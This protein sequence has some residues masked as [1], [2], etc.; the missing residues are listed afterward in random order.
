M[1]ARR[2]AS[3]LLALVLLAGC[4]PKRGGAPS[5]LLIGVDGAD[6]G[7][8]DRL[9]GEG[10]LPTFARLKREGASGRLRSIEPLLSPIVWT[11]I[12]TGRKPQDHGI[13]D[14][15]EIGADGQPTPITS[16]RRKVP[17]LWNIA[18]EF[19]K[20]SGFVGWYASYPAEKVAGFEVSDRLA[21]HQVS[22][23]RATEG[24]T[25]P[26]KLSARL[27]AEFG[28]PRPDL[29]ATKA[30]FLD[31]PA[32]A[33][34][35]DG[36]RRI[37]ELS[38]IHA[39]SEFYRRIVPGLA[40]REPTDLVAVYFEMVDACGHLFMEDAPPKRDDVADADFAAFHDTVDR[41]YQYQDRVLADLLLLEGPST[42][43]IVVSDHGFKSGALRPRTSGRADTGLAPLWHQLHGVVFV[44]GRGARAG[45]DI[46][47]ATVLD[48]A[49]TV[50]DLLG[51]PRSDEFPG[52]SLSRAFLPGA[53]PATSKRVAAYPRLP[54]RRL[55]PRAASDPESVRKLAALGYLGGGNGRV[56]AHDP[57]GR[58]VAS[59]LN[60]GSARAADGDNRGALVDFGKA[61]EIDPRNVNALIYAA[62]LYVMDGN[63]ERARELQD[64]A[65]AIDPENTA[66]RLQRASWAIDTGHL[67]MAE[68]ELAAVERK[69]DNLSLFH[70][71]KA[72]LAEGLGRDPDAMA[73]LASAEKLTDSDAF[74][75]EILVERAGLLARGG[76]GAAA[77]AE[78]VRAASVMPPARLAE[79]RGDLAMRRRDPAAASRF[80][81]EASVPAAR[82]SLERKFG[83]ALA[84]SGD[85]PAAEQAFR[86]A[87]KRAVTPE[88]REGAYG[89]L[90]F[91][92]QFAGNEPKSR[93]L[94]EEA[95]SVVPRSA[96]LWAMRGAALGRNGEQD[97]ALEAYEKS[98][99]I[100]PGPAN[101]KI[102]A[103]LVFSRRHD[104][105][106]A[107]A[108]WKQS[109]A[110]DPSQAD[111]RNF[112]ARFDRPARSR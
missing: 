10:K 49:P 20:T 75:A 12:A 19:G 26:D 38:R 72:R 37:D 15:I 105:A 106:R 68:T 77:D 80:Y 21:F 46:A 7:I 94:L 30:A 60:E 88:E 91:F 55:P 96:G 78:I 63:V 100:R 76:D 51:V 5:V 4:R 62:R 34:T 8:V 97:R 9:I 24:A 99:A 104:V 101:C 83:K 87:L 81:R 43:T 67:E 86:E 73:E 47:G 48:V 3:A 103:A 36:A 108:L 50:V 52:H 66:V 58:T 111:V 112:L 64:R 84:A 90:A 93:A 89:D 109:L 54:E 2:A 16:V 44:H 40:R 23:A 29:A 41:C 65:L 25:W 59:Y 35:P 27:S 110:L 42:T 98:V 45:A 28:T 31:D 1:R 11:T 39:T 82:A 107:V 18:G 6:M 32:R 22:S 92:Y 17:A 79:Y 14:F 57:G 33:L 61:I 85:L 71:L 53:L 69:D 56:V 70:I 95:T 102:L 13:F 74:L